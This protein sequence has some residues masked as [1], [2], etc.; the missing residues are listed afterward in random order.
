MASEQPGVSTKQAA[1]GSLR[2]LSIHTYTGIPIF[3]CMYIILT[4]TSI[5]TPR[6]REFG[7]R[8][9]SEQT[10]HKE[11]GEAERPPRPV[12]RGQRGGV[13]SSPA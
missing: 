5:Y 1:K 12:L 2:P 10:I 11:R 13:I 6:G 4:Y 3:L 7:T 8:P 9:I